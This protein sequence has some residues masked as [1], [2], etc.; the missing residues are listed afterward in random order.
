MHTEFWWGNQKESNQLEE[1]GIAERIVLEWILTKNI[2]EDMDW[3]NPA[4]DRNKCFPV[5]N[6]VMKFWV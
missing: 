4:Q 1:L 3:I 5:L 2:V 6:T